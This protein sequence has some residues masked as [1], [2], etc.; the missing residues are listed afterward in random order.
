MAREILFA[1]LG[2]LASYLYFNLYNRRFRKFSHIPQFPASLLWGHLR[3]FGEFMKR[4]HEDRHPDAIFDDM[5]EALGRPPIMLVDMWPLARPLILVSDHEVAEQITKPTKQFPTGTPKTIQGVPYLGDTSI[6]TAVGEEWKGLRKRFAPGF[7]PQHLMTLLPNIVHEANVLVE[8]LEKYAH[9]GE[10]FS[11]VNSITNMTFDVIGSVVIGINL[12]AQ[13]SGEQSELLKLYSELLVTYQDDKY[14]MPWW[15]QPRVH[16]RRKRVARQIDLLLHEI[17]R[18]KWTER[19]Q[20][21][22]HTESEKKGKKDRAILSLSFGEFPSQPFLPDEIVAT[23]ADQLKSF[24]FAGYDTTSTTISWLLYELSRHPHALA[25]VRA[26][27]GSIFGVNATVGEIQ[28][29]LLA[30]ISS[31]DSGS[32]TGTE[33]GR[34]PLQRMPYISA[35]IKETLRHHPPVGIARRTPSGAGWS[36]RTSTPPGKEGQEINIDEAQVYVCID[37]IQH[38]PRVYGETVQHWRPERWLNPDETKEIPPSAWR[39]FE[40]GPRA[41]IGLELAQIEMKVVVALT[42]TRFDFWKVGL[43][44]PL[45]EKGVPKVG[46]DGGF[47]VGEKLYVVSF[48]SICFHVSLGG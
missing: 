32:G 5:S 16:V 37:M 46:G 35:A 41:C 15:M 20:H 36:V 18:R 3:V 14:D 9:T 21:Q 39:A 34:H 30:P 17:V 6:I 27:L 47:V 11:L 45:L 44:E 43:G 33:L 29:Q 2:L 13:S 26:E 22:H 1:A 28:Q 48:F 23:T 12:D 4:G 19:Q 42:A 24:L 31:G 7:A 38:D 10:E 40:R 8:T 25:A